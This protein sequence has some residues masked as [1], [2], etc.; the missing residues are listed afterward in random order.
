M[1]SRLSAA[2]F[3]FA[4]ALG[5]AHAKPRLDQVHPALTAANPVERSILFTGGD[6]QTVDAWFRRNG[7]NGDGEGMPARREPLLIRERLPADA[8]ALPLPGA[9]DAKLRPLPSG[10]ERLIV[11]RDIV[12]L[13]RGSRT[14]VDIMR[15]VVR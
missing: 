2:A 9:L 10:Y 5:V 4:L 11:G 1:I 13:A 14:I 3:A 7:A 8:G 6:R 15:E 12:L